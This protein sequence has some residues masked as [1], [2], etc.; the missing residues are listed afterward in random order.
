MEEGTALIANKPESDLPQLIP[1]FFL[2]GQILVSAGLIFETV[3]IWLAPNQLPSFV[4]LGL[5]I[6]TLPGIWLR[7]NWSKYLAAFLFFG[8][9]GGIATWATAA[10]FEQWFF[11]PAF[12]FAFLFSYIPVFLFWLQPRFFQKTSSLKLIR[13]PKS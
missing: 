6:V 3:R 9:A 2:A 12:F 5:L 11:I 10:A 1:V 7:L 8:P 13:Q 4:M